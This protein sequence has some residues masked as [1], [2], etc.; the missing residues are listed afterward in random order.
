MKKKKK[1]PKRH[2]YKVD[3][4]VVFKF[5]G[6]TRVGV[7]I[8]LTKE[9][10]GHATYTVITTGVRNR[11]YP[12]LGLDTSKDAHLGNILTEPTKQLNKARPA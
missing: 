2:R 12:C 6:S 4:R 10:T 11:I 3:D 1:I 7:V 8:E 9:S 5:A